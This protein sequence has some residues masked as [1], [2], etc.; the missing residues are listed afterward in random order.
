MFWQFAVW[1]ILV[2]VNI[3]TKDAHQS[4]KGYKAFP[5][6]TFA[7]EN[8]R[9]WIFKPFLTYSIPS[10]KGTSKIPLHVYELHRV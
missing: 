3:D 2:C 4:G 8:W 6:A 9:H 10:G 7:I 5:V 1:H